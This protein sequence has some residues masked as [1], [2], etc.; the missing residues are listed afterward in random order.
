MSIKILALFMKTQVANVIINAWD[1]SQIW[2][3]RHLHEIFEML[4]ENGDEVLSFE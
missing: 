3:R 2:L 4:D 1:E